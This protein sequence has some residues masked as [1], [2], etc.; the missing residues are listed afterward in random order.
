LKKHKRQGADALMRHQIKI[1]QSQGTES[2]ACVMNEIS[3]IDEL[4]E[5]KKMTPEEMELH[6]EI[7]EECRE[8]EQK[9]KEFSESAQRNL[10]I[11]SREI[12]S[13]IEAT[14]FLKNATS[15]LLERT[16]CLYLK[17]LPKERFYND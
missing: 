6:R 9:I 2:E 8:R 13:I 17:L 14:T 7:I 4:I 5:R 3:K 12:K 11:L 16:A 15:E 1:L 10:K